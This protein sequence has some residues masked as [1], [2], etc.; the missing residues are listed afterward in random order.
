MSTNFTKGSGFVACPHPGAHIFRGWWIEARGSHLFVEF[1]FLVL[2]HGWIRV[3]GF[4]LCVQMIFSPLRNNGVSHCPYLP[5]R[6]WTLFAL[7]GHFSLRLPYSSYGDSKEHRPRSRS[8]VYGRDGR[9]PRDGRDGRESRDSRDG[10]DPGREPRPSGHSRDPDYRYRSSESR[11]K[12]LRGDPRDPAFR[13]LLTA[14]T[15]WVQS[16]L[17]LAWTQLHRSIQRRWL[18]PIFSGWRSWWLLP[19]E[20]G[21]L[22]GPLSGPLEWTSWA[23]GYALSD[24][25]FYRV[26]FLC[27]I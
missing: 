13:W 6:S 2:R 22:Q 9:E 8:P 23:R 12:D 5:G 20:G 27:G 3:F 4:Q 19:E 1:L 17:I 26:L 14:K 24:L 10:R 21:T 18:W 16:R 25:K 11:D 7:T 15:V